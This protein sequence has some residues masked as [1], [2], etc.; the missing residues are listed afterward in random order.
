MTIIKITETQYRALKTNGSI[1]ISG[2]TY[3]D[4][5]NTVFVVEDENI[6]LTSEITSVVDMR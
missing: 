3:Y 2:V 1:T 5:A 6:A 4:D